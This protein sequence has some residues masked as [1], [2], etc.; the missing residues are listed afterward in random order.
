MKPTVWSV[1]FA[2]IAGIEINDYFS[3]LLEEQTGKDF[4]I[5]LLHVDRFKENVRKFADY[6][7]EEIG[8]KQ[9]FV[10]ETI[11]KI[12]SLKVDYIDC[13]RYQGVVEEGDD[14]EGQSDE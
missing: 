7:P 8:D 5:A 12:D 6:Y 4:D 14:E 1:T 3:K 2:E 9:K 13:T 11:A 10:E